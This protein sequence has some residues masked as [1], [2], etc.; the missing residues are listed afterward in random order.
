MVTAHIPVPIRSADEIADSL[1]AAVSE[2]TKLIVVSHVTSPTAM[3]LPVREICRRAKERGI[4]VCIDG[5][6]AIAMREVEIKNLGCDFYRASLHKWLSA[7]L[8]SGFLYVAP[9][10]QGRLHTPITSWGRS[11]GGRSA[12]WQDELNWLGTRDP[13]AFLAVPAAIEFLESFGVAKF[14]ESTHDLCREARRM[15]E[16]LTG[17]EAL[18]PDSSDWYGSMITV[19]LPD[20]GPRRTQPNA[21]DPL[22]Q[23]LWERFRIEIPIVDWH[24]R[25][26]IRVS[27]HL[28]NTAE[29]LQRLAEGLRKSL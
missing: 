7:P 13:A 15:L 10:W 21:I 19:P 20:G 23:Q 24:D 9:K 6:H 18:V 29:D 8:G 14:R 27:C 16:S 4:V 12:R 28:Y 26:H 22:Q 25:R 11:L 3:V 5:P 17:R 1:F 2:R